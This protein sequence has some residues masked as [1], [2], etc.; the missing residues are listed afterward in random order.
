MESNFLQLERSDI[1]EFSNDGKSVILSNGKKFPVD[2]VVLATGGGLEISFLRNICKLRSD[3]IHLYR[4]IIDPTQ[5]NLAFNGLN[6]SFLFGLNVEISALWLAN[7]VEGK[8]KLPSKEE[9]EASI[10]REQVW[11]VQHEVG[12]NYSGTKRAN[13]IG[14]RHVAYIESLLDDLTIKKRPKHTLFS[15]ILPLQYSAIWE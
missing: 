13:C 10:C 6:E 9:M 15:S 8:I 11:K 7:V 5:D 12:K 4:H 3:G 14:I 1:S 2:I